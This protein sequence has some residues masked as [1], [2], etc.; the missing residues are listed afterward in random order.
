M[1]GPPVVPMRSGGQEY[2]ESRASLRSEMVTGVLAEALI[3]GALS[4][5][6]NRPRALQVV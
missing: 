4:N 6:E 5:A 2:C 1:R 3:R